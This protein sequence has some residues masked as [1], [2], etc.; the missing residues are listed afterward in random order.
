[1]DAEFTALEEKVRQIAALAQRLR[2]DNHALR[3]QLVAAVSE[4]KLLGAKIEEAKTRLEHLLTQI[5]EENS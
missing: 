3:Q 2:A 4:N 1:M 5:P